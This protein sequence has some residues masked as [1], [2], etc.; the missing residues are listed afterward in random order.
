MTC[1]ASIYRRQ[2][3]TLETDEDWAAYEKHKAARKAKNVAN[4][5]EV[6]QRN[7]IKWHELPTM[8][9][10]GVRF[11]VHVDETLSRVLPFWPEI[12]EWHD[13]L[14]DIHFGVRNLARYITGDPD[15]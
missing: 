5:R 14:G 8:D 12:G 15:A 4:A 9:D 13:Q 10:R 11:L 3:I 7:S 1:L 2:G 6:L